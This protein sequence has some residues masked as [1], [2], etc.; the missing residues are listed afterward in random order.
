MRTEFFLEIVRVGEL[1]DILKFVDAHHYLKPFLF[2]Y[3]FGEVE[4]FVG[5]A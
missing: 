5:V 3:L 4:D 2:G 1:G